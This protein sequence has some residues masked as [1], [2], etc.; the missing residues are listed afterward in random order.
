MNKLAIPPAY[1]DVWICADPHGHMQATGRDAKGRKG[2][3]K[4]M[5]QT[6]KVVSSPL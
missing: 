6:S 3:V 5:G 1:T 4:S 2:A